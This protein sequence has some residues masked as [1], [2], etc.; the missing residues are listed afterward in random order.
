MATYSANLTSHK[1]NEYEKE[2]G[3]NKKSRTP[4]SASSDLL[5][6]LT[7]NSTFI[8]G[9]LRSLYLDLLI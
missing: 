8:A 1:A 3:E 7:Y 9:N 4:A 6:T 5:L 2:G